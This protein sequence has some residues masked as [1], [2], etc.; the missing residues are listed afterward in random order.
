MIWGILRNYEAR[1][2]LRVEWRNR[3]GQARTNRERKK[4]ISISDDV[5]PESRLE[6][7]HETVYQRPSIDPIRVQTERHS[8]RAGCGAAKSSIRFHRL[9]PDMRT[10]FGADG[11]KQQ[12]SAMQ[13][14]DSS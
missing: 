9:H 2:G 4:I 8:L 5:V 3:V 6:L 1:E 13:Y 10:K 11:S 12:C 7:T 14:R